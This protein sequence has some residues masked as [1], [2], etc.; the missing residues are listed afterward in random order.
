MSKNGRKWAK[1]LEFAWWTPRCL[2]KTHSLLWLLVYAWFYEATSGLAKLL[3][4]L[5][6]LKMPFSSKNCMKIGWG[7]AT[8][9]PWD[10]L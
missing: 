4:P 5:S 3:G 1:T 2:W 9:Q 7:A 10:P 8:P 6:E